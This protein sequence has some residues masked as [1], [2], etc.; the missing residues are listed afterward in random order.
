[1]GFIAGR[2]VDAFPEKVTVANRNGA[3]IDH[4]GRAIV[5]SH[6]HD[7]AGHILV[8]AGKRNTSVMMLSTSDSLDAVGN[9]LSALQRESHAFNRQPSGPHDA[10]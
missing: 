6:S 7:T 4:D 2:D 8:A 3:A 9:D 1:M 10:G 5:A